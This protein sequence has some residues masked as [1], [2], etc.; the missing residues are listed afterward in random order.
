[1]KQLTTWQRS[2]E[3]KCP[4]PFEVDRE[5]LVNES[6][7]GSMYYLGVSLPMGASPVCSWYSFKATL[8]ASN[9]SL[10]FFLSAALPLNNN[11]YV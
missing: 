7:Q 8:I 11:K 2:G 10:K 6:C 5:S 1:M 3:A 4:S 9:S